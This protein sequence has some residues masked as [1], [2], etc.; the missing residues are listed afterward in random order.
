MRTCG[1]CR[2]RNIL[3][4]VMNVP[5]WYDIPMQ[6]KTDFGTGSVG[7]AMI[8]QGLPMIAA[9][10]VNVLY[11][12]VD[13]MFIG[14][15][16]VTGRDAITG[17]GVCLPIITFVSAFAF[18][19]GNGGAPLA[20]IERGAGRH[21][22]ARRIMGQSA[23]LLAA[24]SIPLASVFLIYG[25]P[26][27][28][29]FGASGNTIGYAFDYLSVYLLGTPAVFMSLGLNPY[30]TMQGFPKTAMLTVIIGAVINAG[31]DPLFIYTFGM[32]VRG[33][34]LAS[35]IS[36]YISAIW[37]LRFLTGKRAII[38]LK[39]KSMIPDIRVIARIAALG[40]SSFTMSLTESAV[41]TVCNRTLSIYGGDIYIAAMTVINSVRQIVMLPMNGFSQ[42]SSPVIGFN[43]GAGHFDRVKRGIR[44]VAVICAVYA[45]SAWAFLMLSPGPLVRLFNRDAAL[46]SIGVRSMRIYFGAFMMMSMQMAGQYSFLALGRAKQ[47][48]FFSLLRKAI[49]VVPL[50]LL[51]PRF[52]GVNGVFLAEPI[53][54][55]LGGSACFATFMLT[56]WKK[57]SSPRS[58]QINIDDNPGSL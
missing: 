17:L 15:I 21:D 45:T 29:A 52:V 1:I 2:V 32:G 54:D 49:I 11:N 25:R 19:A 33:A 35:I 27:L 46:L 3:R 26:V 5:I 18:L 22:E 31:L 41:Q 40:F 53:S 39:L 28:A 6:D 55:I 57:L 9:S 44:F 12:I 56:E 23:F 58:L 37:A 4:I 38:R 14:Q 34:A 20:A 24:F 51:L 8:R 13:R 7:S 48:I 36:Q 30:I 16:P 50:T 42:G 10:V 43:Y 47:A